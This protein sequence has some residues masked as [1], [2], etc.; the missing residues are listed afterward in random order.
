MKRMFIK[1]QLAP[2][3][4]TLRIKSVEDLIDLY[5]EGFVWL[6]FPLYAMSDNLVP[7]LKDFILRS[8]DDF[9]NEVEDDKIPRIHFVAT[10]L[11]YRLS[12]PEL[13]NYFDELGLRK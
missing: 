4:K 8:R 1:E 9:L 12:I 2:L 10:L 5:K 7:F 13:I 3:E 6:E 11:N